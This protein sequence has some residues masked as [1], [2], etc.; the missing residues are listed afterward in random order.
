M[1]IRHNELKTLYLDVMIND[2]NLEHFAGDGIIISTPI[3]STAYN[4][5]AFGS[6]ICPGIDTRHKLQRKDCF[7]N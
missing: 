2:K 5:S 1:V 6:I 3:G 7:T 4:L